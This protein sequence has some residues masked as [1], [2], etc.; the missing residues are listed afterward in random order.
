MFRGERP[1]P[2]LVV[3][4]A[5]WTIENDGFTAVRAHRRSEIPSDV[6][7]FVFNE[8]GTGITAECD[9]TEP[10]LGRVCAIAQQPAS[11]LLINRELGFAQVIFA[12]I[13]FCAAVEANNVS[14]LRV[15]R[16]LEETCRWAAAAVSVGRAGRVPCRQVPVVQGPHPRRW[17]MSPQ[18]S[19]SV[20]PNTCRCLNIPQGA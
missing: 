20:S 17:V 19:P 18:L 14:F 9:K 7:P 10:W 1:P 16:T 6:W 11:V 15:C 2:F 8:R 3:I 12:S 5:F 13:Y 4:A